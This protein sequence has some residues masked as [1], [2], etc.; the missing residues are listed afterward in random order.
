MNICKI[1]SLDDMYL[2]NF[3]LTI[4]L[5]AKTSINCFLHPFLFYAAFLSILG[6]FNIPLIIYFAFFNENKINCRLL[7][8]RKKIKFCLLEF[9]SRIFLTN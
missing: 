6:L 1:R 8:Y 4:D 9:T 2:F 7:T 5:Y 3:F